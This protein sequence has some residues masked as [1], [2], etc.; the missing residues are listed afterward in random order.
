MEG[1]LILTQIIYLSH[2]YFLN[3]H[4]VPGADLGIVELAVNKEK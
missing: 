4:Y 2:K 3:A 1:F